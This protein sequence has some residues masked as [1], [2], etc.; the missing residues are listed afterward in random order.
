MG[1]K[2]SRCPGTQQS[3]IT[4]GQHRDFLFE[5]EGI[6]ALKSSLPSPRPHNNQVSL[7]GALSLESKVGSY[8]QGE[9]QARGASSTQQWQVW[10]YQSRQS[11]HQHWSEDGVEESCPAPHL[12]SRPFSL[13]CLCL[14][15]HLGN[16]NGSS[17]RPRTLSCGRG[18]ARPRTLSCGRG[19]FGRK[20]WASPSPGDPLLCSVE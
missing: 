12:P 10:N 9:T 11:H 16:T 15:G 3:S 14:S 8:P 6:E 19:T 13:T 7:R 20:S 5:D 4:A 2:C 17:S 1:I 18:K